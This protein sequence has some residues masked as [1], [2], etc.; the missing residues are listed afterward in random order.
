MIKTLALFT[1]QDRLKLCCYALEDSEMLAP[2]FYLQGIVTVRQRIS[3]LLQT[4]KI[5]CKIND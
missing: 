2:Y 1:P 4:H 5:R 3:I